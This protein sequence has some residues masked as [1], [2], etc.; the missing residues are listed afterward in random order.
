[1]VI[2]MLQDLKKLELLSVWEGT[3]PRQLICPERFCHCLVFKVS[4]KSKYELED[5]NV[6]LDKGEVLYIPQGCNYR[7]ALLSESSNYIAIN[8]YAQMQKTPCSLMD[9]Q[10]SFD[11]QSWFN[12]MLR[13]W[14]MENAAN[15]YQCYSMFY[16]MLAEHDS[17]RS[18]Q[19]NRQKSLIK[20]SI[21]YL[22]KHLF[23]PDISIP[24]M[25]ACSRVS[26]SYFRQLFLSVYGQS[27]KQY[28]KNTRL[29]QAYAILA[30]GEYYDIQSVAELVGY[31]DALYFSKI[32]KQKYGVA[33]SELKYICSHEQPV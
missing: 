21:V 12:S 10:P 31:H 2:I 33:P 19:T 20:D 25:I 24:E 22:E 15:H 30:S 3:S 26:T 29:V 14:A 4:G 27:P 5:S 8:F 16:R 17:I 1:M 6:I 11:V 13:F 28:I 9:F 7:T 32:F 18:Y 23:D